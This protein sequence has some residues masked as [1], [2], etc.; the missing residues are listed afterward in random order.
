MSNSNIGNDKSTMVPIGS[1]GALIHAQ[2]HD[3]DDDIDNIIGA[4]NDTSS[5]RFTDTDILINLMSELKAMRLSLEVRIQNLEQKIDMIMNN[6]VPI[7]TAVA[8][9][10]HAKSVLMSKTNTGEWTRTVVNVIPALFI[11]SLWVNTHRGMTSVKYM[12]VTYN[13]L[14]EMIKCI[15]SKLGTEVRRQLGEHFGLVIQQG[16]GTDL[17]TLI[18]LLSSQKEQMAKS[19]RNRISQ[20]CKVFSTTFAFMMP[21]DMVIFLGKLEYIAEDGT[22]VMKDDDTVP[23]GAIMIGEVYTSLEQDTIMRS[24]YKKCI[25]KYCHTTEVKVLRAIAKS[26]INGKLSP[27]GEYDRKYTHKQEGSALDMFGTSNNDTPSKTPSS[28][29]KKLSSSATKYASAYDDNSSDS[30]DEALMKLMKK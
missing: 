29:N 1:L 27:D 8:I 30:D 25:T 6:I 2:K 12:P 21:R 5:G 26:M 10:P 22:P 18:T 20:I 11:E 19:M 15:D 13:Y 3:E 16:R 28:A 23:S 7:S 17:D 4:A 24:Q 14:L 9:S